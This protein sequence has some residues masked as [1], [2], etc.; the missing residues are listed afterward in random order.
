MLV[1]ALPGRR[2]NLGSLGL[3]L[4]WRTVSVKEYR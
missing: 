2:A 3:Q 1:T 4:G